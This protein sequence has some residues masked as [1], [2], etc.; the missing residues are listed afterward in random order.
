MSKIILE[1][2]HVSKTYQLDSISLKVL[3]N[4]NLTV[5][6]GEFL[7]IMGP[8]GSGKST[9]MHLIGCLDRPSA[10]K[11]VLE[12]Q[13]VSKLSESMLADIRNQKI[14]FV[15][16]MYNLLPR[17]TALN[18]I[19][20]PLIYSRVS[21]DEGRKRAQVLMEKLGLTNRQFHTSNQLSGGEQQR[22]AIARA[23]INHPTLILADEPTG[24]LDTH[25]GQEILEILRG[26]NQEGH[27]VILVTH[28]I[29]VGRYAK[30]IIHLQDGRIVADH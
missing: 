21:K 2:H 3:Q 7:A 6:K 23:L 15:F 11:V 22:V 16:Q 5:K 1:L 20:L 27:T 19:L 8:S 10:G 12:G 30:K 13:D 9:L 28:D 25:S 18:N 14:G 17:T 24:N 29:E 4:I 26:L